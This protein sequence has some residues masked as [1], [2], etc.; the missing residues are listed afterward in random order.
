M[1]AKINR[2]NAIASE[3]RNAKQKNGINIKSSALSA[4]KLFLFAKNL[5]KYPTMNKIGV[6]VTI[7]IDNHTCE[8][9]SPGYAKF[10][11]TKKDQIS[12]SIK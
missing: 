9:H 5:E 12:L 7:I 4:K 8:R 2:I 11:G 1:K 6:V 10:L 3:F